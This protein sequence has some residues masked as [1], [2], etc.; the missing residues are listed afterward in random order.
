MPDAVVCLLQNRD[1][2]REEIRERCYMGRDKRDTFLLCPWKKIRERV[3]AMGRFKREREREMFLLL[4]AVVLL[5]YFRLWRG[6]APCC[7]KRSMGNKFF[8]LPR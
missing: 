5:Q 6:S 7:G 3:A 1:W 4:D 2:Y 8:G